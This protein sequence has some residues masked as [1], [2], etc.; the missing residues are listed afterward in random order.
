MASQIVE[1]EVNE[2]EVFASMAVRVQVKRT[3]RSKLGLF[4]I[5]WGCRIGGAQYLEEF[6][7]SLIQDGKEVEM[8]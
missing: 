4:L 3:W 2:Q 5:K 6:P 7:M 1:I 8:E